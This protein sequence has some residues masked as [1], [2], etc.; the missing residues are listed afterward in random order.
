[1]IPARFAANLD[2]LYPDRAYI[3]RIAAAR[4]DGFAAVEM[5]QPHLQEEAALAAALAD[6]RVALIN[7]PAGDWPAGERGLMALPGREAEFR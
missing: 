4:A 5:L 2:W 6:L 7:A 1:M 3:D